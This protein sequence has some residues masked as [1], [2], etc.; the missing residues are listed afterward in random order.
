MED[1]EARKGTF[2]FGEARILADSLGLDLVEVSPNATP[3]VV[4]VIDYGK[5]RYELQKKQ[6]VAKKKQVVVALKSFN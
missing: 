5:Y 3:P 2:P 1:G 4:K 6:T